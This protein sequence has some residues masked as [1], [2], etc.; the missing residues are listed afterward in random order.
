[1]SLIFFDV[2]NGI[3]SKHI[4][5]KIVTCIDKD[6][7]WMTPKLKTAIKRNSRVYQKWVKRGRNENDHGKVREVQKITSKL[8]KE[9]KQHYYK[10]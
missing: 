10:K 4:P 2:L 1:M 9:A 3:F 5:N 7:P 8:I 6:A